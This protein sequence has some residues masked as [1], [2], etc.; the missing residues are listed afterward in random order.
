[1]AKRRPNHE[2][3]LTL[4]KDGLW[5]ARVSHEGK[6][7]A[8]Y[9]KTKEEARQKLQTLQRKQNQGLPLVTSSTPVRDYLAQWLADVKSRIRPSTY[10]GYE[11]MVRVHLIPQLGHIKLG[12]LAPDHISQAWDT[13]LKAGKSASVVQHAHLRLAKALTD[14][15]KRQLVYRNPCQAVSAPRPE[16]KELHPPDAQAINLLLETAKET[17]YY[18]LLHTAFYTGLRR[19]EALALRWR[20]VDL[21]EGSISVSR[22]LYQARGGV[23]IYQAPKTTK[24]RRLVSLTPQCL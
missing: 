17:E 2:G 7:I 12:K 14:A 8:A 23:S 18:S 3:S 15:V 21:D 24:G 19:N 10:E 1:M 4:R 22:S 20:D 11:I 9:G 13:M 16:A 5:V 6:R